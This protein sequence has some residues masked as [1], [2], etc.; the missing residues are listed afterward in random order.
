MV[1]NLGYGML[2]LFS[3]FGTVDPRLKDIQRIPSGG[4]LQHH[5]R[6]S[7]NDTFASIEDRDITECEPETFDL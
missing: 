2:G 5:S 3:A 1:V 7:H 6:A 4:V